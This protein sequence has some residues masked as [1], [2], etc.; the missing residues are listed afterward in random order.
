MHGADAKQRVCERGGQ[1]GVGASPREAPNDG[2]QERE[3]S[4]VRCGGI[5]DRP[6]GREGAEGAGTRM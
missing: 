2:V 3:A 6:M 1:N 5:T 4:V